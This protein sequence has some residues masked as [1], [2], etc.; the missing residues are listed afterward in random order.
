MILNSTLPFLSFNRKIAINFI[1]NVLA[2]FSALRAEA[3]FLR[4]ITHLAYNRSMA[5]R[6]RPLWNWNCVNPESAN[7]RGPFCVPILSQCP[8]S[9]TDHQASVVNPWITLSTGRFLYRICKLCFC[10]PSKLLHLNATF[11]FPL[12]YSV[13][14]EKVTKMLNN[15]YHTEAFVINFHAKKH[16][17][18]K[19]TT[20]A[21]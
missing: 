5:S 3:T 2:F 10:F 20:Y 21:S 19:T 16:I 6:S 14:P 15:A 17:N 12:K 11:F 4:A 1:L 18:G 7:E 13:S 9:Y 8:L